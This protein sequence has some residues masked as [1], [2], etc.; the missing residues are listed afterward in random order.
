MDERQL[1]PRRRQMQLVFQDPYA[2]LN[3]RMT[4]AELLAEPLAVQRI[5]TRQAR[6]ETARELLQVVGLGASALRRYAHE[7][8][9]GQRQRLASARALALRPQLLVLDEPV[10]ALDVSIQA[11]VLN[12]LVEIQR[13]YRLTYLFI[14]HDLAVVRAMSDRVAVMYLGKLAEI[15]PAR[16]LYRAPAHPYTAGLLAAVPIPDPTRRREARP[17][18][19]A[20]DLPLARHAAPRLPLPHPLPARPPALSR[21]GAGPARLRPGAP[22][23]LPLP[24]AAARGIP[25]PRGGTAVTTHRLPPDALHRAWDRGL[26]PALTIDPRQYRGLLDHR[27]CRWRHRTALL[28]AVHSRVR[29]P[30]QPPHYG[31]AGPSHLRPARRARGAA[32]RHAGRGGAGD[33]HRPLGLDRDGDHGVLGTSFAE[34]ALLYWDLRGEQAVPWAPAAER[35]MPVRL[36]MRPFCGVMGPAPT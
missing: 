32:G 30:R 12:L 29:R 7:F 19:P 13:Q 5:G 22:G 31:R 6:E 4:V 17:A 10:S 21:R 23:R 25:A 35:T 3:P 20:G 24:A 2:S 14:A 33:R 11:Q 28:G 16:A 9:G 34:R 36:P 1:R 18:V 15:A 8:S 27:R 26:P